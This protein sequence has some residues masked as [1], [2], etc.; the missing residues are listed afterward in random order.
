MNNYRHSKASLFLMEIMLNILFFTVLATI[1]LQLF[2]KAHNLSDSTTILHRATATCTS[3]AEVYQCS[4]NGREMILQIFPEA[5]DLNQNIFI[6]FDD[7]FTACTEKDSTYCASISFD[8]DL[9]QTITIEFST[10]ETSNSIYT[11]EVSG[12][13]PQTL[14]FLSGGDTHE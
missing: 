6:Y 2:V 1:C 12:Y 13:Q 10:I 3:I 4:S 9:L 11:L 7:Q 5:L 8:T 14:S